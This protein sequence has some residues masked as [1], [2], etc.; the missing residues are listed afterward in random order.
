MT[1]ELSNP[2]A[3]PRAVVT[4]DGGRAR[5]TVLTDRL[6]RAEWS[7][8][9]RLED[10][11]SQFV[12]NR[13]LDVPRFEVARAGREV[14]ITTARVGLFFHEDGKA[15]HPGNLSAEFDIAAGKRGRW[16]AGMPDAGN[17]GGTV[18]TL[19][20]VD[21]SCLLEPGI[22]S[23]DGWVVVDDSK[24]VVFDARKDHRFGRGGSAWESEPWPTS[25]R[26]PGAV[27]WYLFLHGRDYAAAL[28][29]FIG[30]AGRVPLPPRWIFGSWWSRYWEY[31]DE[32]L[33]RLIG[34]FRHHDVPLDVLV[35]DM[36]WHRE[37][38]T[39]YSWNEKFFPRPNEFLDW[40]EEHGLKVTLNLHPADGVGRHEDAFADVCRAMG[41]DEKRTHRVPFNSTD[42]RFVDAYFRLLHH[43]LERQG[44]DFWWMDWQQGTETIVPG[45]DPL[46]WLNHLH[47]RDME[48]R[49][50][51]TAVPADRKSRGRDSNP[52]PLV[53]SRWGGLGNHRYQ[54]G[55]SGDTHS[56]WPSL[57]FQPHFT[58]T[59]GN[60]GYGYWSHDIG[61]H[62]P[63]P[64]EPEMYVRWVQYAALSPV[65]R[66]HSSKNALAERRIWAFPAR[67]FRAM[68]EAFRFRY[69][70]IPHIYTAARRCYE[71]ARPLCRPLYHEWPD[72]DEAYERGGQYMFGEDLLAAPV[73]RAGDSTGKCAAAEVWLPPGEWTDWFTGRTETG[74]KTLRRAVPLEEIP[75]FAR[76][77]AIIAAAPAMRWSREKPVDPLVLHVFPGERGETRV[78]ED[79][80]ESDDYRRGRC[81]WTPVTMKR[82]GGVV[83]VTIGPVEGEFEGMLK[84]RAFEVRLREEWPAER[85]RVREGAT[86]WNS[87]PVEYD[88][89]QMAAVVRTEPV[90]V[91]RRIEIE[92]S[93]AQ[94]DVGL[95]RGGLRGRLATLVA[96]S[97][98]LGEQAPA[99]VK[100]LA[101]LRSRMIESRGREALPDMWELARAIA[102]C[103]APDEA[104]GEA[105][106][107]ALGLTCTVT[108]RAGAG[109]SIEAAAEARLSDQSPRGL[110]ANIDITAGAS[111]HAEHEGRRGPAPM[112][113]GGALACA[114]KCRANGALQM[115]TIAARVT[116]SKDGQSVSAEFCETVLPSVNA[117]WVCG[118]FACPW[119][120]QFE[121]TIGPEA[122]PGEFDPAAE[123]HAHDGSAVRWRHEIRSLGMNDDPR[124]EFVV[125]LQRV[126]GRHIED[127]CA[128]AAVR[129]RAA[130]EVHA[131]LALGSDD[132]PVV[133][134]NGAEV[135][136]NKV[137]R[138]YGTRQDRV[139]IHLRSG[140]NTILIKVTQAKGGW[141]FGA[142]L[143][144]EDGAPL[145][146]VEVK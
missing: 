42:R 93:L 105:M 49:A 136:R 17:L 63:G 77:G 53:F 95:L 102:A 109:G 10:R 56:T 90:D 57:A 29:D 99:E 121:S 118:P 97:A 122:R 40:T 96:I 3:D 23:R 62:Q 115:T 103:N 39:G 129:V 68:R 91:R 24:S 5:F 101:G 48:G 146:G 71:E 13:R 131:V 32:E 123:F 81:A 38:W 119:E 50:G 145:E 21:G 16:N 61:G 128:F 143:E 65:L 45:L 110:S 141:C 66:T 142:H 69:S 55:F 12:I 58:A 104:R 76:S 25:R 20:G 28:R 114:V 8:L 80:G 75:I 107:R 94:G 84:Q 140:E 83:R 4:A 86:G 130:S 22:L 34:E 108:V 52:R 79:D 72:V 112:E 133:W 44:I 113:P 89:G 120:A 31:T 36:D 92:V 74:P 78:Y 135:H 9:G 14:R 47:W 67:H 15:F 85:V 41:L 59:A 60:V 30:V 127:A 26:S 144:S 54:I 2:I 100:R 106:C 134:V 137:Q 116:L 125:D 117:W 33:K 7:A 124:G 111:W 19:D 1:P 35:I 6:I 37:G 64:V 51:S 139:P 18:R 88:E 138:G 87:A 43:P 27:D 82:E 46:W 98:L 126:F 73:T 11:A 70:L 132:G